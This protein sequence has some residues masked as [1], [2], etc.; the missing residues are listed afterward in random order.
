MDKFR[1]F[2]LLIQLVNLQII[3]V[4]EQNSLNCLSHLG[5]N[6]L[7]MHQ[8]YLQEISLLDELQTCNFSSLQI[9]D[10]LHPLLLGLVPTHHLHP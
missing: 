8:G 10:F 4:T 7:E 2:Q 6:R 1:Q 9:H 3:R 5:T